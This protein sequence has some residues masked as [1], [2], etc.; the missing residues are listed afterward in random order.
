MRQFHKVFLV[1]LAA[2]LLLAACR[3]DPAESETTIRSADTA[4]AVAQLTG[5]VADVTADT[6]SVMQAGDVYRFAL[7]DMYVDQSLFPLQVGATV[8]LTYTGA[9]DSNLELQSVQA[10]CLVVVAPAPEF[11]TEAAAQAA[12]A[13]QST[14]PA[15]TLLSA[16]TLEEKVGQMFMAR[17]PAEHGAENA[18]QF[19]L[20]GYLLFA[21]DFEHETPDTIAAKIKDYQAQSSIKMLI[22]VDEE[23]GSVTRVSRFPAFRAQ[24][25]PSSRALYQAGGFDSIRVDTQEKAILLQSIGVNVNF[26]PVC[27]VSVHEGEYMYSRSFGLGAEATAQYVQTVVSEYRAQGMGCVLKHFPGYGGNGDTHV[28][29]V[30]DGRPIE[31]FRS[32]DFVP[33]QAGIEAG[34]PCVLVAH[35]IVAAMD[36]E[37]PASLSP[38]VHTVLR[39]EL[40]FSGVIITDD[41]AMGAVQKYAA[42]ADA[43]VLAVLAG[44]DMLVSSNFAQQ[45]PAV[46]AAVQTGQIAVQQIDASVRRILEWKIQL[47]LIAPAVL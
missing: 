44:N 27:D 8:Q 6:V 7:K 40:G 18:A 47:G 13:T 4:A 3:M 1:L 36:G 17:C 9:L 30:Q 11:E 25:F 26:A 15:E 22:G 39:Q 5:T 45:V 37:Y 31:Q 2:L 14:S 46:V 16:M 21:R 43:A 28:D 20:G 42:G 33:F 34:A 19:H 35:N 24:P 10:A 12:A 29:V 32:C 38:A 41:L 23:G